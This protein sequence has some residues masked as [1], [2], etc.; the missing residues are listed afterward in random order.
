MFGPLT[1]MLPLVMV[2]G[3]GAAIVSEPRADV[4]LLFAISIAAVSLVEPALAFF[5]FS[6]REAAHDRRSEM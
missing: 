5:G 4:A 3:A 1:L 6:R 2:A